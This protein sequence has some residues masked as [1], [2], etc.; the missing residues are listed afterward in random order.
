MGSGLFQIRGSQIDGNAAGGKGQPRIFGR[1]TN[2]L[3]GLLHRRIR[4]SD[5]IKA[6]QAVG[7]IALGYHAVPSDTGDTQGLYTA[8]HKTAPF[9][10]FLTS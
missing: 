6:R 1:G 8:D 7:N 3:P 4:Q 5:N 10:H 2:S 9:T